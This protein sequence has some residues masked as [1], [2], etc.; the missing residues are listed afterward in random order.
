MQAENKQYVLVDYSWLMSE[1]PNGIEVYNKE[2]IKRSK[3]HIKVVNELSE[4]NTIY[5]KKVI[6]KIKFGSLVVMIRFSRIT[7]QLIAEQ[8]LIQDNM[9]T[10]YDF[11]DL[12]KDDVNKKS[13]RLALLGSSCACVSNGVYLLELSNKRG[14]AGV[15]LSNKYVTLT[16]IGVHL[17]A[18]KAEYKGCVHTILKDDAPLVGGDIYSV[19]LGIEENSNIDVERLHKISTGRAKSNMYID[20]SKSRLQYLGEDAFSDFQ[21]MQVKAIIELGDRDVYFSNN[22]VNCVDVG[23]SWRLFIRT[24]RLDVYS[25]LIESAAYEIAKRSIVSP[26]RALNIKK[27]IKNETGNFRIIYTGEHKDKSKS[28]LERILDNAVLKN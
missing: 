7:G 25:R 3:G 19:R 6:T 18:N 1:R 11:T 4:K 5:L 20:F 10:D 9:E 22:I 23:G 13:R 26:E 21:V 12:I 2:E 17:I 8:I 28:T 16:N 24:S 15:Y 27:M 14:D